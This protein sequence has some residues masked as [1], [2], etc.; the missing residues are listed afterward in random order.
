MKK[1]TLQKWKKKIKKERKKEKK[2]T[3]RQ[4]TYEENKLR[5]NTRKRHDAEIVKKPHAKELE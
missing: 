5:K 3:D 2:R 4:V 1:L